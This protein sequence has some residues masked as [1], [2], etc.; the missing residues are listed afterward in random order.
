MK[1]RLRAA[2]VDGKANAQLLSFLSEQFGVGK[3]EVAIIRGL[4]SRQKT[5]AIQEPRNLP[6]SCDI[7]RSG[8]LPDARR[9][10]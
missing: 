8:T 6:A 1:I 4:A 10:L 5:V 9:R 7:A 2:P 3:G